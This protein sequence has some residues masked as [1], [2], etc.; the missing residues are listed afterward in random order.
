MTTYADQLTI[1]GQQRKRDARNQRR[2]NRKRYLRPG[3]ISADTCRPEDLIPALLGE[4]AQIKLSRADRLKVRALSAEFDALP[5]EEDPDWTTAE[6]DSEI[7]VDL[8]DLAQGYVPDYCSLGSHEGDGALL[9]V[10]VDVECAQQAVQEGEIWAEATREP[11]EEGNRAGVTE[12]GYAKFHGTTADMSTFTV[13]VPRGDLYLVISDHGNCSLYQSRGRK[14]SA[15]EI[16]G[17]V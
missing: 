7:W 3:I 4:L 15:R 10:W 9:G 14:R 12:H 13:S 2:R 6:R 5:R 11:Y 8:F 16:W 17:V 1:D